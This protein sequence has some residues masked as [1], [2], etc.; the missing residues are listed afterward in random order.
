MHNTKIKSGYYLIE[1]HEVINNN[2]E[3]QIYTTMR[4]VETLCHKAVVGRGYSF[5][6][7]TVIV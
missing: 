7:F 1:G 2:S 6:V 4:H 3:A 5:L